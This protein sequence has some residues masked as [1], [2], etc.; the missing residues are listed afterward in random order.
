MSSVQHEFS[1]V[2]SWR[3]DG[4]TLSLLVRN[5]FHTN[6]GSVDPDEFTSDAG[7][8]SYALVGLSET[9][10]WLRHQNIDTSDDL[11]LV[12]VINDIS[13][14]ISDGGRHWRAIT[15]TSRAEISP[16]RIRRYGLL[17][18]TL[19]GITEWERLMEMR[20]CCVKSATGMGK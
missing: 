11:S 4:A 7:V 5:E 10:D 14:R 6:L 1:D 16:A 12:R 2:H 3:N 9:K 17:A 8:A 18:I 15:R 13:A 19:S 20:F